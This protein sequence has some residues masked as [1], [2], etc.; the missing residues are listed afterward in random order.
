[1]IFLW[2]GEGNTPLQEKLTPLPLRKGNHTPLWD[3]WPCSP[4]ARLLCFDHPHALV[5]LGL[6]KFRLFNVE[7]SI[8]HVTKSELLGFQILIYTLKH[9]VFFV[10]K[11]K[12]RFLQFDECELLSFHPYTI[13]LFNFLSTT[14]QFRK[15]S[16]QLITIIVLHTRSLSLYGIL[17]CVKNRRLQPPKICVLISTTWWQL[18]ANRTPH[19]TSHWK[20]CFKKQAK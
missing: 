6:S 19:N 9:T 10:M 15:S 12:K 14:L 11:R 2:G 5:F 20:S 3:C 17:N 13:K 16:S 7:H 18:F 8:N 4:V 1:M